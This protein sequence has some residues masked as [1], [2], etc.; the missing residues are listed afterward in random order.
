[1]HPKN[2]TL[3][4]ITKYQ[5]EAWAKWEIWQGV[6]SPDE[7]GIIGVCRG[8]SNRPYPF[9]LQ[10]KLILLFENQNWN[11]ITGVWRGMSE[12]QSPQMIYH[13]CSILPTFVRTWYYKTDYINYLL[14]Y[15]ASNCVVRNITNLSITHDK[16]DTTMRQAIVK[17][18]TLPLVRRAIITWVNLCS[19][20]ECSVLPA[21]SSSYPCAHPPLTGHCVTIIIIIIIITDVDVCV[22][23]HVRCVRSSAWYIIHVHA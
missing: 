10:R 20:E 16:T 3:H 4:R 21:G 12:T 1:M 14:N 19:V 6:T 18:K 17:G 2:P 8:M 23:V 7:R 5:R 11:W 22:C 9:K 15:Q 13:M